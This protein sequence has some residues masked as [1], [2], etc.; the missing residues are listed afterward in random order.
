MSL[1]WDARGRLWVGTAQG[2][3]IL[4][5]TNVVSFAANAVRNS[6][7]GGP[8]GKLVGN[9]RIT[10]VLRP[11]GAD[12][13]PRLPVETDKVLEL[14]GTD[15]YVELPP[16]IF[17]HLDEATVEAWV[18]W[19]SFPP[20]GAA[21][22]FNYGEFE[23]DTGIQASRDG[24][25]TFFLRD[26][27]QDM[28]RVE[29]P[30]LVGPNE[31]Y[32]I[33]VVTGK[34]GTELYVNGR[35]EKASAYTGSFSAIKNGARFRLGRSV[36]DSE[37]RFNGQLDEVRVWSVARTEQEI[38]SNLT[39]KL[40]GKEPGLA[41]LWN[42][43]SETNGVVA[44]LGPGGHHALLKGKAR[45]VERDQPMATMVLTRVLKLDGTN[46][47]VEFP[48]DAFTDLAT[49]T[50]EGWIKWESFRSSSRFFDFVVGGQT[51]NLQ[52][53]LSSPNLWLER[54]AQDV[55][56]QA[57]VPA[58][59]VSNRWT[60]V[61]A[62]VGPQTL[63]LFVDGALTSTNVVRGGAAN[64]RASKR[65]YLGRSNWV[66]AGAGDEDFRG[67]MADVRI[68]RGERTEAQIQENLFKKLTGREAGL[69]GAWPLD[70]QEATTPEAKE[71]RLLN[72][73][74]G[75][76]IASLYRD[77]SGAMWIGANDGVRKYSSGD[78]TTNE[79]SI[80][81]FTKQD[82][83]AHQYVRSI[84]QAA[85][86]TMWFGTGGGVSRY[87]PAAAQMGKPAF[88]T[89][90]P[91]DG[92]VHTNVFDLAQDR[93]GAMWFA[94]GPTFSGGDP[95]LTGISRY[96]GK[97]FIN[98]TIPDGLASHVVSTLLFDEA[99][100]LWAGTT[101]GVSRFDTESIATYGIADGL[102]KGAI[103]A[104]AST[105]DG[106]AWFL[107][108]PGKLSRHDGNRIVKVTQ[109]D[110]LAGSQATT[111]Y[112]DTDGSLLVG[113]GEAG[114]A[115]YA[116]TGVRGERPRFSLL[117]NA[118]AASALARSA[119]G[120]LWYGTDK[121]AYR[122]GRPATPE[123]DIGIVTLTR[124]AT[125][126]VMWFGLRDERVPRGLARYDGT[127]FTRFTTTNGLPSDDVRGMQPLPDGMLLAATMTG[128]VRF[129]GQKFVPWPNDLSRLVSLRC[130][131]VTRDRE[132]LVW[133]G[134]A[135]GVFLTDGTAWSKLDERDGL[136]GNLVN[137]VHIVG[138]G[139]VWFGTW[140]EGVA[141]YH[142]SSRTPRSPT[143]TVQTDRDYTDLAALPAIT[144]GQRVTF[145]FKVVEFRTAPE[146]R[147]YRWQLVKGKRTAD[148]LRSGWDPPVTATQIE[149]SFKEP[150]PWT[151]AVQ[152]IDRDLNYSRPT[153]AVLN[154]VV[155]WHANPAF[156]VPG[157][158]GVLGLLGWAFVA[159]FLYARKR[160]EAESLREQLLVEEHRAK[161]ALEAKAVALAES[162]RQLEMARE[163]AEDARLAADAANKAKSQF[164][165]NMSHELRTPLNAI[166]GYSE[167]LQ[168]EAEDTGQ[169]ALVPD[170]EKIH[171][172]GKHL[173]GLINDVLDLSK[174]EAGKMT[175]Y[176]EDFEVLKLVSEVAATVQPL[177][178]KNGNRLEV[179][180][181][182]DL[183]TMR[184][185]V[186]KVRQTLFNL[187]SNAS[188][189]TE[190][191][192]IRLVIGKNEGR[193]EGERLTIPNAQPSTI[194]FTV[195]DTGI[196]MT[197]EQQAKLFQAFT[198]ADA[199]TS[200][201][202]GGTGLGLAIS[203]KFCQMMGGDITVQSE[204]GQG[205]T[206]TVTLPVM[207]PEAASHTQFF[208]KDSL[209]VPSARPAASATTMLV[210]DDDPAVQDLMRRSM[211]KDGFRVEVAAD[212]KTGIELAKQLKPAVITL[213]VMMPHMDGW[214]VLTA[215][216]AEVTTADIPVIML[217]IVDDKQMGFALGAADYF[218][219][220]I[221]FQRLHHV[222]EKYRRPANQQTVLVIEDDASMREMLRRTLAK[223]GWQVAEAPNGKVGLTKLDGR[224][225][226]LILLDLMMPEMDGFEFME[227]L[228]QR[229]DGKRVPVIVITAKDLTE[230]DHRRLNGGVERIIQKG[231]TSQRQV[232]ELVRS[233]LTGKTDH[234]G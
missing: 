1:A 15:G 38:Q 189:F 222:L 91:Q 52:N 193:G 77:S 48:A 3:T 186:T 139:T 145:K 214:S 125:N 47:Y 229:G 159:R 31:W 221:D 212:G 133:L 158:A 201:K 182:P 101:I 46:S 72:S 184:A 75:L 173:L 23:H 232:L 215:L 223:E 230:E 69:A 183:G 7:P 178:A 128:P 88:T 200:R 131:D 103:D 163:S 196:G 187:L 42:F 166:I 27:R 25:V 32:H 97:S 132:G 66:A 82:G 13:P 155:P 24:K 33:A 225:P 49:A 118:P 90:A 226:A 224:V 117:E 11:V 156:I 208:T 39:R 142:K 62:V 63:K 153:L 9:A 59:L 148:D 55:V 68:W 34:R 113:D 80:S 198:Q 79:P 228:R 96:D 73:L 94:A 40:T 83:L 67:Q 192:T 211:E 100:N 151:L 171:G 143:I 29:A 146:K 122:L 180:C 197:R 44:D 114:V 76:N 12:E 74:T 81:R 220:P 206:F 110:G 78:G 43:D 130:Y 185:D 176:L 181:P 219:K 89:F 160:R 57:E 141:R 179:E 98:F 45:I 234:E 53:R 218:T 126:G 105:S 134:T 202:F 99:G 136:P 120:E 204:R 19:R 41:A 154:V 35:L 116:P 95:P 8:D 209:L 216:K 104:V 123:Q 175:L 70:D 51:F 14:D 233:L 111:L 164:L 28:Q 194:N 2:L 71:K 54:D 191:G 112:T 162:N 86:G 150:G 16:N 168:E 217:T 227:A 188:K 36:V 149:E 210:I 199:S 21:R 157:A 205:S 170:L 138:N 140:N 144:T 30:Q 93:S 207:V 84:L 5:G 167:M 115:R 20:S 106:N 22:F 17:D 119:S 102:D 18:K 92:L 60:H 58:V 108:R 129:D 107:A 127:N 10:P 87:D 85:D 147:Q 61:A 195:T 137:R 172:A 56:D 203:R 124:A 161:E 213:D 50:V 152:F 169:G 121:G 177:I 37:P 165:A 174:I 231:A 109:D 26:W 6:V 135:Q 65:N 190:K 4:E 64:P